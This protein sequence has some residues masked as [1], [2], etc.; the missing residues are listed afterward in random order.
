MGERGRRAEQNLMKR[1]G[2]IAVFTVVI[3]VLFFIRYFPVAGLIEKK[4]IAI[5]SVGYETFLL[6][7][8]LFFQ[9]VPII[10]SKMVSLRINRGQYKN[11]QNLWQIV[12]T[13]QLLIGL[14][15]TFLCF[16]L[17]DTIASQLFKIPYAALALKVLS[18]AFVLYALIV[19]LKGY[20]QG[21][22]TMMPTCV[23]GLIEQLT[24]ILATVLLSYI[25]YGHGKKVAALLNTENYVAAY[26]AVAL[27]LGILI[28]AFVSLLFLLFLYWV[29]QRNF[30]KNLRQD[31]SKTTEEGVMLLRELYERC[32][33][34]ACVLLLL[35]VSTWINQYF[36]FSGKSSSVE[37]T[38]A[39]EQYGVYYSLYRVIIWIPIIVMAGMS[40]HVQTVINK[41]SLRDSYHQ[42]ELE[43]QSGI[44]QIGIF[45]AAV[46]LVITVLSGI[47][48]LLSKND[49]GGLGVKMLLLGGF[50]VLFYGVMIYTTAYLN[51]LSLRKAQLVVAVLAVILQSILV[52]VLNS[53]TNL[54]VLVLVIAGI[55]F[56]LLVSCG[57]IF[58]IKKHLD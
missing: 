13:G 34:Y 23:A 11:V 55:V 28:G 48:S 56:P 30:K 33:P 14:L 3:W 18:P 41:L 5:F 35:F 54:G 6:L 8:L 16:V 50:A 27:S 20:F 9:A 40:L 12:I 37:T 36:F 51:G 17:A 31:L 32:L 38:Q 46:S 43:F 25:F 39:L 10:L 24:C 2:M 44:R 15:C 52:Y 26:G 47:V 45:G 22:G 21:M 19:V 58:I 49:G 42:M 1:G 53:F 57:N 7:F 4:G 29:Y